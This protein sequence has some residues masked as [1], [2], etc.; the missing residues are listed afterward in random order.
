MVLNSITGLPEEHTFG[1][2]VRSKDHLVL[3][4]GLEW[5]KVNVQG[6]NIGIGQVYS[7]VSSPTFS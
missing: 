1:L 5:S 7:D 2:T 6:K 3:C 4:T